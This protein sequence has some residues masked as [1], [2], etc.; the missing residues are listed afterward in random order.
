MKEKQIERIENHSKYCWISDCDDLNLQIFGSLD[1]VTNKRDLTIENYPYF[2]DQLLSPSSDYIPE[3]FEDMEQGR[4]DFNTL[5]FYEWWQ[6]IY[7]ELSDNWG[8]YDFTNKAF[9]ERFQRLSELADK[10]HKENAE[11]LYKLRSKH[12]EDRTKEAIDD[13]KAWRKELDEYRAFTKAEI[14]Q[15]EEDFLLESTFNAVLLERSPQPQMV[16]IEDLT[17]FDVIEIVKE[18]KKLNFDLQMHLDLLAIHRAYQLMLNLAK[19]KEPLSESVI[20]RFLGILLNKDDYQLGYR[21]K[22]KN[23]TRTS[24]RAID[25][26]QVKDEFIKSLRVYKTQAKKD[27]FQALANLYEKIRQIQPFEQFNDT[28]A[29]LIVNLE[30][31]KQGYKPIVIRRRDLFKIEKMPTDYYRVHHRYPQSYAELF[32]RYEAIEYCYLTD[33]LD[34]EIDE[35]AKNE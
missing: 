30:L 34:D 8:K 17:Q 5:E 19:H 4:L 6:A 24:R 32:A 15:F 28:I 14:T 12:K 11:R 23:I 31:I 16:S 1:T 20:F 35:S 29:N 13:A 26:A 27:V 25:K 10:L 9:K 2:D 18:R 22:V 33:L 7:N 3:F 21:T